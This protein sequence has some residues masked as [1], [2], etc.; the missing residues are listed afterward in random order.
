MQWRR[1]STGQMSESASPY[2][3]AHT[4]NMALSAALVSGTVMSVQHLESQAAVC[5]GV[6]S[7]SSA[8]S[9]VP[10]GHA[11]SWDRKYSQL[12]PLRVPRGEIEC[13][14]FECNSAIAEL[15][16]QLRDVGSLAR[17]T[18]ALWLDDALSDVHVRLRAQRT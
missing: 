13:R 17:W 3:L 11:E 15:D 9:S 14:A 1:F 5:T 8:K 2:G 16:V 6:Q 12:R 18:S 7:G 4:G 10:S